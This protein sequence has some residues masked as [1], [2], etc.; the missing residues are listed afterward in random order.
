M[1]RLS[2]FPFPL[3]ADTFT[4]TT[5]VE[6]ARVPV[7]TAAGEWGAGIV[8]P[9]DEYRTEVAERAAV[10][11]RDP[12]RVQLL[13]HMRPA[14]WDALLTLLRELAAQCPAH[15]ALV[16]GPQCVWR[17]DLLG[18]EQRFTVG[19]D[20]SLPGGP[21]GFLNG[22][23]QEDV[24]LLDQREDAL[25]VDAGAVA[26]AA[27]WSLAFVTGMRF[28]EVHRPVVARVHEAGVL[29]RAEQFL[30][31]LPPGA[32]YR[33]LNWTLSV[34]RRLDLS[35]EVREEWE[36]QRA[37]LAAAP[38]A[39]LG[40]RVH[41][42]V[43]LQHLIRLGAS[44]AVLFLIRTHLLSLDELA[45][46]PLWRRRVGRVLAALPDDVADYKGL[47]GVRPGVVRWCLGP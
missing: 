28:A 40:R 39:E 44:G 46:V 25:W 37:A 42:R 5:N 35:T 8:E 15:M 26:F 17:N 32:E 18:V 2:R 1:T 16:E 6:P 21:L 14:A 19:D 34:D 10:V 36:P 13:P 38:P 11:A 33:R 22:Q 30:L 3:A 4:Y 31:R 27:D 29:T 20:E 41:L 47:T 24:V 7:A 45:A 23:L 43:E 12:S 9:D